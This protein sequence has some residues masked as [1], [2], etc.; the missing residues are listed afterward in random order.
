MVDIGVHSVRG[1]CPFAGS[2]TILSHGLGRQNLPIDNPMVCCP[3]PMVK[4][5]VAFIHRPLRCLALGAE[6]VP[7]KH[8]A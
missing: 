3:G 5:A 6:A 4:V 1:A 2:E 7:N 8:W